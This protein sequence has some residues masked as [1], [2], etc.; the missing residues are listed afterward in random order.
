MK[1]FTA[2]CLLTPIALGLLGN[3]KGTGQASSAAIGLPSPSQSGVVGVVTGENGPE[4]GVW[5]IAETRDLPTRLIKIV[6][7][8][9]RGR[10]VIPDLPAASYRVWVRGYGLADSSPVATKPGDAL[11]LGVRNAASKA[12]AA[13]I[14]PASYWAALLKPPA[15]GSWQP[16]AGISTTVDSQHFA[17]RAMKTCHVCHQIGNKTTREP[18]DHSPEGWQAAMRQYRDPVDPVM[19]TL[20]E[21]YASVMTQVMEMLGERGLQIHAD[22]GRRIAAGETP[23]AAPQRPEGTERNAVITIWDWVSSSFLHDVIATDPRSPNLN[24]GGAVYGIEPHLGRLTYVDPKSNR[25]HEVTVDP[26]PLTHPMLVTMDQKRRVWFPSYSTQFMRL[27]P[28]SK[29]APKQDCAMEWYDVATEGKTYLNLPRI[30]HLRQ[31]DPASGKI[32]T[33][34]VCIDDRPKRFDVKKAGY[35]FFN[36]D[37]IVS[38]IDTKR[39]DET[40]DPVASQ[41]WCPVVLNTSG[42]KRD[43]R[44]KAQGSLDSRQWNIIGGKIDPRKD[45]RVDGTFTFRARQNPVDGSIWL[46]VTR[47]DAGGIVRLEPGSTPPYSCKAEFYEP[48]LLPDNTYD[49]YL[50]LN[51]DF[52]Q[53]GAV[54]VASLSGKLAK[55]DR[56]K[57]TVFSGSTVTGQQC[58]DGWTL[59]GMPGPKYTGTGEA[60][61]MNY[62]LLVDNQDTLGLGRGRI[63]AGTSGSDAIFSLDPATGKSITIRV[64]YPQGFYTRE[65][66]GRIDDPSL[67]WKG[68]SVWASYN[69]IPVWQNEDAEDSAPG[70]VRVQMRPSPLAH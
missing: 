49:G 35:L 13:E 8:D 66:S 40:H 19:G 30:E 27:D 29:A 58:K 67:G 25:V 16:P 11:K 51:V 28:R 62:G 48:P 14:Y 20:G 43:T 68:R 36:N 26:A 3:A 64:P 45:T 5:V 52:D 65:I 37:M 39:W 47:G 17:I 59:Y 15:K 33:I 56:R 55:F 21:A 60:V 34:P 4:A 22:W 70:L 12:E 31:W 10:F 53:E 6:V 63:I 46:P 54:W 32:I 50:P 24:A 2:F 9:D 57:C 1:A 44:S 7:T 69:A 18:A 61:D 41:G 38:W 42:Q 23:H